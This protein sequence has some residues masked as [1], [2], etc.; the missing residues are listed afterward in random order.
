MTGKKKWFT[1]GAAI[2]VLLIAAGLAATQLKG[3]HGENEYEMRFAANIPLEETVTVSPDDATAIRQPSAD[4]VEFLRKGTLVSKKEQDAQRKKVNVNIKKIGKDERNVKRLKEAGSYEVYYSYKDKILNRRIIVKVNEKQSESSENQDKENKK[5]K[6]DK[7]DKEEDDDEPP[8]AEKTARKNKKDDKKTDEESS[9]TSDK[10]NDSQKSDENPETP[11]KPAD[12]K[13]ETPET[14]QNPEDPKK[15]DEL[16]EYDISGLK[17]KNVVSVFDGKVHRVKAEGV[18]K[19]VKVKY[20]NNGRRNAGTS[21][22]RIKFI[23]KAGYKRIPD[24]WAT[25]TIKKAPSNEPKF[26]GFT[27]DYN[28]KYHWV[29][30][31]NLDPWVKVSYTSSYEDVKIM[32]KKAGAKDSGIYAITAHFEVDANHKEIDSK[33]VYVNVLPV[34]LNASEYQLV[35]KVIEYDGKSHTLQID[36]LK[37]LDERLKVTYV[38]IHSYKEAGEHT[39]KLKIEPKD[40]RNYVVYFPNREG[41]LTIEKRYVGIVTDD[42]HSK[43]DEEILTPTY[44]VVEGS[45]IET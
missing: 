20:F 12:E 17:V 40:K 3:C 43:Y 23:G 39:I 29:E 19:G 8:H 22:V 31:T 26:E 45:L 21:T 36:G 44:R 35:D 28:G 18:P 33:T 9:D 4:D 27:V 14:P 38:G 37:N 2:I 13:P 6:K 15:P 11:Q 1:F 30:A 41:T 10:Q 34:A 42:Q 16:K 25:I 5:D 32:K 7:K 24:M